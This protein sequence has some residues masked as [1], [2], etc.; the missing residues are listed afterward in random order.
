MDSAILVAH[1]VDNDELYPYSPKERLRQ[2]I[3]AAVTVKAYPIKTNKK[4]KLRTS[5]YDPQVSDAT[6]DNEFVVVF[7]RS[8][9]MTLHHSEILMP[10]D[11]E[12]ELKVG[13]SF[14]YD[15]MLKSVIDLVHHATLNERN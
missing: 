5:V 9:Y 12:N 3:T 7:T 1:Y 6:A 15:T 13:S 2:D 10:S 8:L 11:I 14:C 4:K